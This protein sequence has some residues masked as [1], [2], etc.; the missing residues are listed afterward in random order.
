MKPIRLPWTLRSSDFSKSGWHTEPTAAYQLMFEFLR[1]SPSYELARKARVK[2]LNSLEQSKVPSDFD[3]VLATFDLIGD[4]NCIIFRQWWLDRGLKVF[5]NPYTKPKLHEIAVLENGQETDVQVIARKVKQQLVEQRQAEG[6]SAALIVSLPL[7]LKRSELLRKVRDLVD[8]YKEKDMGMAEQPK[9]KLMGKR[10]HSNAM[11]KGLRLMWLKAAKPKWELWRLGAKS[12]L[13]PSYSKEL[14]PNAAR[15]T[16]NAIEMDDRI[17]MGKI[18]FRALSRFE[19]IA[20]NAA[21]GRFPCDEPIEKAP[22][23]YAAI[24]KRLHTHAQWVKKTKAAWIAKKAA[25]Q[26]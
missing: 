24:A 22:Y 21:R 1:L 12:E 7:G 10:F 26:G 11:F 18:T 23:D 25:A 4:V 17:T 19:L 13:S 2:G 5:G 16:H 14:D 3:Q 15:R 6:L 20:E 8:Q 9:I